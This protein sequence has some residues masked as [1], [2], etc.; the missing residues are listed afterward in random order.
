MN[1]N[2]P[3][4]VEELIIKPSWATHYFK[5]EQDFTLFESVDQWQ[6]FIHG[7]LLNVYPQECGM[8][9]YSSL[10]K[11]GDNATNPTK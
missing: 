11:E 3:L 2:L 1:N 9:T 4:S 7:E 5:G 6:W 10:I 8:L